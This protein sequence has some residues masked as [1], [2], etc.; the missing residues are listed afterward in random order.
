M[1]REGGWE[2]MCW[3]KDHDGAESAGASH[4]CPIRN[5]DL[6]IEG[7]DIDANQTPIA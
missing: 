2:E 6:G 3:E 4:G 1:L 5:T 7:I